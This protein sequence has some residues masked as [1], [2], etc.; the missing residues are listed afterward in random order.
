MCLLFPRYSRV[1]YGIEPACWRV[2]DRAYIYQ[3]DAAGR[4]PPRPNC[5][6]IPGRKGA[7]R[8]GEA[9]SSS[10]RS[11]G[12]AGAQ[13]PYKHKVGGSNPSATTMFSQVRGH[14]AS[15]LLFCVQ[16]SKNHP[17]NPP[18]C[19]PPARRG[20]VPQNR[21]HATGASPGASLGPRGNGCKPT[22]TRG[23]KARQRSG[24][25]APPPGRGPSPPNCRRLPSP[26]VAGMGAGA[27]SGPSGL[28][29]I[30]ADAPMR[31]RSRDVRPPLRAVA[32]LP[33][34]PPF[35]RPGVSGAAHDGTPIERT[36]AL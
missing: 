31:C 16:G 36:E 22:A 18:A 33:F 20:V 30:A 13:V 26:F 19:S 29:G 9:P 34:A 11:R 35:R 7:V 12:A 21:L 8:Q 1:D 23:A 17:N 25:A 14:T 15:D 27:A 5:G 3:G 28:P 4:L 6:K 2:V 24:C 10:Q 32:P